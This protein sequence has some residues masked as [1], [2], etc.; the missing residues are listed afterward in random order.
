MDLTH[1]SGKKI[2]MV[3]VKFYH[4][5]D[6]IIRK[7][8]AH[9]AE[10]TFF[11][12]RDITIKHAIID[13]FFGSYMQKWQDRH[14]NNIVKATK[15]KRFD[16]LLVVRGF[17]M[18]GEF[19]EKIKAQNPGIKTIMY[20]WDSLHNWDYR[21]KLPYFDVNY[22]F[23]FSDAE[24]LGIGYVPTF[25]TD[26]FSNLPPVKME[27]NFF[28]YGNYTLERYQKM[29]IFIE[30]AR[31]HGYAIKTHLFMG[32]KRYIKERL[33]KTP[34]DKKYLSFNKMTKDEY[35]HLFNQSDI[36]VDITTTTQ[37]GLA[38]RMI[39]VLGAGKKAMT[40][41]PHIKKEPVYNPEQI[42]IFDPDNIQIPEAFMIPRTFPKHMYTIDMWIGR[43]FKET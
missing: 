3:G 10:V 8:R 16:Y 13:A 35:I 22:S 23:D 4:Y 30:Y 2:L 6:E 5:N 33:S 1:L 37:T 20:Q 40:N 12:E 9:G 38:M 42:Y 32:F 34:I 25:H 21:D 28:F 43:I 18:K 7:L 41:N 36:I 11:Y 26:E 17:L 15:G 14:Y 24:K 29:L 39:D 27:Y 19:V 31:Q